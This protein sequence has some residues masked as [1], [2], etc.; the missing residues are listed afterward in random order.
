M[1]VFNVSINKCR[2]G[3]PDGQP[4][5]LLCLIPNYPLLNFML[6]T[7]IYVAVSRFVSYPLPFL[8]GTHECTNQLPVSLCM[9]RFLTDYSN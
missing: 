6:T 9:C 5:K 4:K 2:S 3:V 7:A 1:C 8:R